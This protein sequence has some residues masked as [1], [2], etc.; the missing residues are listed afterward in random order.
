M[1]LE[2][3]VRLGGCRIIEWLLTYFDMVTV[4]HKMVGL[5]RMSDY[6]GGRSLYVTTKYVCGQYDSLHKNTLLTNGRGVDS[7]SIEVSLEEC[8]DKS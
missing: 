5:E 3:I 8:L 1:G 2:K 4:P 6:R 7:L